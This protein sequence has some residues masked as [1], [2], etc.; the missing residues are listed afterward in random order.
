SRRSLGVRKDEDPEQMGQ[1]RGRRSRRPFRPGLEVL[2]DRTAPSTFTVLNTNDDGPGSLRQA[3]LDTNV[4]SGPDIIQFNIAGGGLP[5]LRPRPRLPV[6][7]PPVTIDGTTQPGYAGSPLI[8]LNGAAAG[9]GVTGLTITAAN[10]VVRGL[11]IN[12]F[13]SSAI[14]LTGSGAT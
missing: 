10:S 13:G 2:E 14:L 3:I 6:V 5:P 7:P 12:G 8:E 11:V 1:R 4:S 9:A